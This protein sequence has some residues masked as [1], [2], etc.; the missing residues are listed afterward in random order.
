MSSNSTSRFRLLTAQVKSGGCAA[1]LPAQ[2]LHNILQTL[3]KQFCPDLIAG[4]DKFDDAAVYKISGEMA[5]VQTVDFF[6][7]LVDDPFLFGKIAATNAL[8]DIYAMGAKPLLALNILGFPTC[9]LP[10]EV[11]Q[12][13]LR[14]AAEQIIM[15]GAVVAGGHT[16]QSSELFYGLAVT[17]VVGP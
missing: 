5:V 3:P 2:E 16:I 12:D 9:D 7:P 1:K 8:S 17:G 10:L 15:A 14:G 13:I 6:P 11:A 4:I